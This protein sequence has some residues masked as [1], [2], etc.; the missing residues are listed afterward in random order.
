VS[1]RVTGTTAAAASVALIA[2]I[3][4]S[5]F[6]SALLFVAVEHPFLDLREKVIGR[7]SLAGAPTAVSIELPAAPAGSGSVAP[8][9]AAERSSTA[10]PTEP[11]TLGAPAV[12]DR[13]P[14]TE[15]SWWR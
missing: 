8:G 9:V 4:C 5:V 2:T 7:R 14:G 11:E 10:I 3:A 13:D 1:E 6:F 12:Q 15:G